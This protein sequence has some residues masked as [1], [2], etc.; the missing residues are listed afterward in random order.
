MEGFDIDKLAQLARIDFSEKERAC[1]PQQFQ[2]ILGYYEKLQLL[3]VEGVEPTAHALP[4]HNV[5]REDV[6]I[7]PFPPEEALRNAP[8]QRQQ[9]LVV[10]RV[11]D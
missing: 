11:L 1:F 9:Q 5:W 6:P 7:T 4:V 8:V 3:D 2:V 10:P